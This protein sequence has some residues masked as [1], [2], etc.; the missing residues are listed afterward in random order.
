MAFIVQSVNATKKGETMA[1]SKEIF[2]FSSGVM[3]A[4]NKIFAVMLACPDN[5]KDETMKIKK[6]EM[7]DRCFGMFLKKFPIN[8]FFNEYYFIYQIFKESKIRLFNIEQLKSLVESNSSELLETPYIDLKIIDKLDNGRIV[9][10]QE[11]VE[12]FTSDIVDLVV[13][14]SNTYISEVDFESACEQYLT[15]YKDELIKKAAHTMA[16]IMMSTGYDE[17]LKRGGMKHWQ[18]R[19]DAIKYYNMQMMK[20]RELDEEKATRYITIDSDY[21]N[22]ENEKDVNKESDVD[23]L[24][25]YGI[26]EMDEVCLKLR[27]TNMIEI[28]GAPKGGKTTFTGYLVERALRSK[29]NVAVWPL[30]GKYTEWMALIE[31]LTVAHFEQDA[32]D[33]NRGKILNRD[34]KN[35]IER[36]AI[37]TARTL[38]ASPERGNLTFIE[39]TAYIEDFLDILKDHYLNV[40]AYDVLV[41]DSPINIMSRHGKNKVERISEGYMLLKDF[42]ANRLPNGV[43]CLVTAQLKQDAIDKLRAR[44]NETID[45]TAGGESAET[46]RTPD[47]IIGLFSSKIERTNGQMKIYNVASR[48]HEPF[49]DFFIGCNLASGD[50]YS[51]PELNE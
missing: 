27:R 43:L 22:R 5:I 51:K 4:L 8:I 41:L 14:L 33:L 21:V 6:K 39:G 49:Q 32:L 30:E 7:Y 47:E 29:L 20:I 45:V 44:P 17:R 42:V 13:E 37:A 40:N 10:D 2:I 38:L 12:S 25:D 18:G 26:Q 31:T 35:N 19:E 34:F 28:M 24:L 46:I 15:A 16:M 23:A 9:E 48:H 11:K 36:Q 1:D 3:S 50:F